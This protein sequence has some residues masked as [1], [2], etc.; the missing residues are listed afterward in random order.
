[1][2]L[3]TQSY[4]LALP[5][6][7]IGLLATMSTCSE[8][9]VTA[10]ANT[11]RS[12]IFARCLGLLGSQPSLIIRSLISKLVDNSD[13][14]KVYAVLGSLENVIPLAFSP[15][16]TYTYN[17]TLDV[18]PGTIYAISAF[19]TGIAALCFLQVSIIIEKDQ[20]RKF[21]RRGSH[22]CVTNNF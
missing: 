7:I 17:N 10:L 4:T 12:F 2:R 8:K 5:D 3:F 18:Y 21:T 14:G 13:L 22:K 15:I 16:L 6:H 9:V 1:M 20:S 19:I 11:G